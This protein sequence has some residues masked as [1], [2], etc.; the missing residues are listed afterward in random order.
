MT[1]NARQILLAAIVAFLAGTAFAQ[2]IVIDD[3]STNSA[4]HIRTAAGTDASFD[5]GA[6]ILQTERNLRLSAGS[7]GPGASIEMN[8]AS[9]G[10]G[11]A[12]TASLTSGTVEMW[13]DGNNSTTTFSP[14]GLGGINLTSGGQDRFVITVTSSTDTSSLMGLQVWTDGTNRSEHTFTLPG[15]GGTVTLP[16][17][18]FVNTGGAGADFSNVG[19]IFLRTADDGSGF[20]VA[21]IEDIRTQP[22]ELQSFEVE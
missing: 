14:T 7:V 4:G 22:V 19:A 8:V 5:D 16:Y 12:R 13:W 6:G 21:S 3:F 18:N 9:G 15:A 11:F 1:R 10:M 17:A 2:P 20:W